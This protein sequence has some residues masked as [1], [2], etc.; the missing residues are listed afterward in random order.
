M[1]CGCRGTPTFVG[2]PAHRSAAAQALC[3]RLLSPVQAGMVF[4]FTQT[5]LS[6]GVPYA[7]VI[8]PWHMWR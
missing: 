3:P 2:A 1:W 7:L 6:I 5:V 8:L 4:F